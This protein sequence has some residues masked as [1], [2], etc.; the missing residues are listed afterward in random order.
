[1]RKA[2][3]RKF[4]FSIMNEIR[5][6]PFTLKAATDVLT[7]FQAEIYIQLSWLYVPSQCLLAT[8]TD[9]SLA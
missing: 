6:L 2:F 1:M 7:S 5:I 3:V 4:L 8:K 9:D